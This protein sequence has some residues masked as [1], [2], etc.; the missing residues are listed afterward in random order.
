MIELCGITKVF[1]LGSPNEFYGVKDVSLQLKTGKVTCLKGPS[2]SGK[3]TLLSL[4]GCLSRPSSGRIL[5]DDKK[6]SGLPERFMANI[7][8][9]TFG[10]IFQGFNLIHGLSVFENIILPAYPL[11]LPYGTLREKSLKLLNQFD[12]EQKKDC[13]V[14]LL[15]GGEAQRVAICRAMINDPRILIADEPTASLDSGLSCELMEMIGQLQSAG[16]TIIISSHDPLVF[17]SSAVGRVVNMRDGRI[18]G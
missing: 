15:S 12:M 10:F 6:L 3:T 2:G 18:T 4:I 16:K 9:S 14:E 8:R 5:L 1:N 11:G 7:R 17:E 13:K